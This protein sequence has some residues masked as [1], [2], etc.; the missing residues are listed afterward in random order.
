MVGDADIESVSKKARLV[1]PVPGGVG[2][3]T[4]SCL[5]ENLVKAW[6]LQNCLKIM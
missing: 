6:K 4:V 2:P 3:I 1:T 5:M